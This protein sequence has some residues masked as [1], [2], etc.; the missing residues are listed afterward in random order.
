MHTSYMYMFHCIHG[1]LPL[2]HTKEHKGEL[3]Q[4]P[5]TPIK[6]EKEKRKK[7][8]NFIFYSCSS[9]SFFNFL[10][11]VTSLSSQTRKKRKKAS[12]YL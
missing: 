6:K 7:I 10:F 4:V 8:N 3:I 12:P 2:L 11:H 1:T 9:F 5:T